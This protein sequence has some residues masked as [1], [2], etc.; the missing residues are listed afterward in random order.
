MWWTQVPSH[1]N[2][3]NIHRPVE[4]AYIHCESSGY[5]WGAILNGRLEARGFWSPEDEHHHITWKELKAVRLAVL[6]FLPH[7][8]GRN[9]LLHEDNHALCYVQAGLTSCSPEM[10]NELRRLWYMLDCNNIHIR[11]RYIRSAANT[12]ADKLSRH[13]DSGDM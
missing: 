9:M 8:A 10:M 6:S 7:L 11:P 4:S 3:K 5:G 12:W 2:G 1:A 13:L